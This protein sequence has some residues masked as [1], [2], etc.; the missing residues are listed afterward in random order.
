MT[1]TPAAPRHGRLALLAVAL[2]WMGVALSCA[3]VAAAQTP[4]PATVV[5][6]DGT[7]L[8]VRGHRDAAD[9][10][11]FGWISFNVDGEP[12]RFLHLY[13]VNDAPARAPPEQ[14]P[15]PDVRHA[16]AGRAVFFEVPDLA[17]ATQHDA[18]AWDFG[19]GSPARPGFVA[20]HVY[21]EPGKYDVT[22]DGLPYAQVKVTSRANES[23]RQLPAGDVRGPVVARPG[24]MILGHP[25]GTVI[26][27]PSDRPLVD[28]TA[29]NVTVRG[30]TFR[31]DDLANKDGVCVR[32]GDHTAL[33]DV[34]IERAPNGVVLNNG[35]TLDG[36]Y[37]R[38]V[39]QVGTHTLRRY[40]V[41]LFGTSDRVVLYDLASDNSR[42]E[43][44]VRLGGDR[45]GGR[46][47]LATIHN[48]DLAN[49]GRHSG[50]PADDL[51]KSCVIVQVGELVNVSG[52]RLA[53][54]ANGVGPLGEGD[55]LKGRAHWR[56]RRVR[57]EGNTIDGDFLI[58]HGAI[59]TAF[60]GNTLTGTLRVDGYVPAYDR[61]VEDLV[62]RDLTAHGLVIGGGVRDVEVT[63]FTITG[64]E[65]LPTL[66]LPEDP[67]G[68]T[69]RG[70]RVRPN[71]GWQAGSVALVGDQNDPDH[72]KKPG[73]MPGVEVMK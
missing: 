62:V 49:V 21:D 64:G 72:Y 11:Y 61:T 50:G 13:R 44:I 70:G 1:P 23:T 27:G 4:P 12:K 67:S 56:T 32:A 52:N 55:G 43:H 66:R 58:D 59:A 38:N 26:T 57:V 42:Y 46:T 54:D 28:A 65:A 10:A 18:H 34:T 36:L 41:G 7:E 40:L 51:G 24:E 15:A 60:V 63:D 69:L 14:A 2:V 45:D 16:L 47:R 29:G 37:L 30:V 48:S 71:T 31:S 68:I 8:E 3:S 20:A 39:R 9:P 22:L 73:D 17:A 5:L 19:D 25:D 35:Q 6:A 53:S 33:I